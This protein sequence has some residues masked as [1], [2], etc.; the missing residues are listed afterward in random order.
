MAVEG[1]VAIESILKERRVFKPDPAFAR[2]A[3]LPPAAYARLQKEAKANFQRYWARLA[4]EHVH[5]FTPWKKVLEWKAPFAK[6]F[7]GGKTNV[8]YNCLDRH[9]EGPNAWRRNKAAI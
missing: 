5:W 9:V 1:E 6:W 2:Q 7:V 3:N 8:A 4:K